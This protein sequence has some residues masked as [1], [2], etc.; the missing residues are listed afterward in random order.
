MVKETVRSYP[1]GSGFSPRS[2]V[3]GVLY[4]LKQHVS[5]QAVEVDVYRTKARAE[6]NR[7]RIFFG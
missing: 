3:F 7:W 5:I 2:S 1:A 6:T 4:K